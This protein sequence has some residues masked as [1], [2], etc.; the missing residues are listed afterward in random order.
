MVLICVSPVANDV[1]CLFLCWFAFHRT[2]LQSGFS[3]ILHIFNWIVYSLSLEFWEILYILDISL[4][5]KYFHVIC[6][7]S[8]FFISWTVSSMRKF[9]ILTK[10][11]LLLFFF[12]GLHFWCLAKELLELGSW[13][14]FLGLLLKICMVFHLGLWSI[15]N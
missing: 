6:N 1:E 14:F 7:F 10:S 5:C 9:L 8:F 11:N 3:S 2:S 15:L 13:Q 12:Y 4:E